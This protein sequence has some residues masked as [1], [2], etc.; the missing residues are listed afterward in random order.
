MNRFVQ[1]ILRQGDTVIAS[2]GL[3]IHVYIYIHL[4]SEQVIG[5]HDVLKANQPPL[6]VVR[7][8]FNNS[9]LLKLIIYYAIFHKRQL[10]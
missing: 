5:C 3:M 1:N 8:L 10:T 9:F 6:V 7:V 4:C 2:Q